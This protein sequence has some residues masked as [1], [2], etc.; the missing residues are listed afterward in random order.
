VAVSVAGGGSGA[1]GGGV[2]RGCWTCGCDGCV[3]GDGD[4]DV[5]GGG[6]GGTAC[7]GGYVLAVVE[8]GGSAFGFN[9]K[10]V[11]VSAFVPVIGG[12]VSPG[13]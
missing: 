7:G 2:G 3:V 5:I 11:V 10:L 8:G 4:A 1:G 12:S 9:A 13:P 6:N